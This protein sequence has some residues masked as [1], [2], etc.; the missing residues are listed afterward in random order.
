[1]TIF[2]QGGQ[3][4]RPRVSPVSP[5]A[6][7]SLWQLRS[8]PREPPG[9]AS[10]AIP[11]IT[12][13]PAWPGPGDDG[14]MDEPTWPSR[15]PGGWRHHRHEP[16]RQVR[17]DRLPAR[18]HLWRGTCSGE[19]LRRDSG[20]RLIGGV[21]AGLARWRGFNP[22]TVRIVFVV[23]ALWSQGWLFPFYC[24]GW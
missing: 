8:R 11:G 9:R 4:A 1:M 10:G 19:P 14:G 24:I 2:W 16:W 12:P 23:V 20:D 6:A 15:P 22:T 5:Q 3:L 18:A 7:W 21:A 17:A 13:M